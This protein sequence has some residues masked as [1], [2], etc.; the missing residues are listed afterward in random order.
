[1]FYEFESNRQLVRDNEKKMNFQYSP[2]PFPYYF[3][4][5]HGH[6]TPSQFFTTVDLGFDF[7][8]QEAS[9]I[10]S[11]SASNAAVAEFYGNEKVT[12]TTEN[13]PPITKAGPSQRRPVRILPKDSSVMSIHTNISSAF[14]SRTL[15]S[16]P[17]ALASIR[18]T[19]A[20]QLM[21]Q[22]NPS[23]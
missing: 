3:D 4:P 16:V 19:E 22:R 5:Q 1:L 18:S 7:I 9:F 10:H 15:E 12:T 17:M 14:K 13:A 21:D 8:A 23:P 20:I 2:N 6:D 11:L